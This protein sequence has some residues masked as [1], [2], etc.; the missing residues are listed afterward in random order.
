MRYT[1][2]LYN[3]IGKGGMAAHVIF[4][5]PG[6]VATSTT[7]SNAAHADFAG[8]RRPYKTAAISTDTAR[9]ASCVHTLSESTCSYI[10]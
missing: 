5:G 8:A 3:P 10:T 4:R 6:R 7:T 1:T 2:L 9:N